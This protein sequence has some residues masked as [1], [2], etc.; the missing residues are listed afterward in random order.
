MSDLESFW[1]QEHLQQLIREY[2]KNAKNLWEE[3]FKGYVQQFMI[4][5]YL[6]FIKSKKNK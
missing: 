2:G 1:G 6:P 4:Q 5:K 3:K